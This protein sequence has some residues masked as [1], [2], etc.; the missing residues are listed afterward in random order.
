MRKISDEDLKNLVAGKNVDWRGTRLLRQE[1]N[2]KAKAMSERPDEAETELHPLI[3]Q[4]EAIKEI[5]AALGENLATQNNALVRLVT[6]QVETIKSGKKPRIKI[7]DMKVTNRTP[8]RL[9]DTMRFTVE[10]EEE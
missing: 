7:I 3:A 10:A 2:R 5:I 9:I 6:S 8:D 1:E 4:G